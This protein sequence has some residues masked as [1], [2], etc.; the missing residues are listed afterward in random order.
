MRGRSSKTTSV[1]HR[2]DR[3]ASLA[4]TKAQ[5]DV[6]LEWIAACPRLRRLSRLRKGSAQGVARP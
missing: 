5:E 3:F 6:R 4:M 1:P 2:P